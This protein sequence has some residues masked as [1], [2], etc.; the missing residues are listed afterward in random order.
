MKKSEI[1]LLAGM[2]LSGVFAVLG[3]H[4]ADVAKT[5]FWWTFWDIMTGAGF[6]FFLGYWGYLKAKE[7]K[8]TRSEK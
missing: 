3:Q 4:F 6:V 1:A 8:A 5:P 7:K 2:I